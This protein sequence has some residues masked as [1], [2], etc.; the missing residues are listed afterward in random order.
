[1]LVK[2]YEELSRKMHAPKLVLAGSGVIN[3]ETFSPEIREKVE[4]I[5]N[6]SDKELVELYRGAAAL[7]LTSLEEGFG[8]VV[9]EAMACRVPPVA[10]RCGGP[11]EIITDGVDG[12]LVNCGDASALAD[13]LLTLCGDWERNVR[14]GQAARRTSEVKFSVTATQSL[15]A[16][17]YRR[18]M[19]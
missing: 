15:H 13:R 10:T 11:E 19:K 9:V 5:N 6:P 14:T 16:N 4:V 12:F 1:M 17:V 7:A 3:M 8:L 2:A 18:H